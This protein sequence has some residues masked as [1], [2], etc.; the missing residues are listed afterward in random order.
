MKEYYKAYEE[1]YKKYHKEK[2]KAWAGKEPS[3]ILKELLKNEKN[4]TILEI[5]CG[6]GQNANYL[7]ENGYNVT[8]SDVSQSAID[9]CKTTYKFKDKFFVLDV[10]NNNHTNKYDVI[11]TISTLHMLIFDD[12]RKKFLDFIYN[13]LNDNGKAIITIM[14]DG[15]TERN[16]S[17]AS[18]AFDLITRNVN[19]EDVVVASTTCRIVNWNN[20]LNELSN[21]NLKP[22][23]YYTT[24]EISGFNISM[25]AIV[26]KKNK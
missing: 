20:F 11:Y 6:E 10:L 26:E 5:G 14:G 9:W 18:K 12:D 21:S 1:R 22:I 23:T 25:L 15:E 17:D 4:K 19:G 3:Y 7:L 16:S 8:A 2:N 13:H 24:S